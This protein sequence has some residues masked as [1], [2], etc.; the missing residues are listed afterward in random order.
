MVQYRRLSDRRGR[1][2]F[3]IVGQLWGTLETLEATPLR[4]LS[5]DGALVESREA[6]AVDSIHRMRLTLGGRV[7]DVQVRVRHVK[8]WQTA[9]GQR[10]LIGFEFLE[11]PSP[12][13]EQIARAVTSGFARS[14]RSSEPGGF[15]GSGT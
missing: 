10:Y 6:L 7:G 14:K 8:G 13:R 5:R 2:R 12:M 1:L 4:N 3:E 15:D 9:T 11:V